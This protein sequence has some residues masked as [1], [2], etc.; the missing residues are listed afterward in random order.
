MALTRQNT[1]GLVCQARHVL[2]LS[3]LEQCPEVTQWSRTRGAVVVLGG[4]SNVILPEVLDRL[5]VRVALKGMT[6]VED[7]D[8]SSAQ[9]WRIDVAA[10][11]NWHDW[12]QT[13][14]RHGWF[15]LENLAL[16]PGTVG[17]APVQNIGA[18]GVELK[19]RIESVTAW[20]IPEGRLITLPAQDC[21]FA[22]RD[23][24]F[25]RAA[26]GTWLIVSV[27]F[28]LPKRWVPVL[29]YPDLRNHPV[30]STME[31]ERVTGQHIL[32]AVCEIRRAKLPDPEVLGNAG[33]FFKNPVVSAA[34]HQQLKEKFVD[35]IAYPQNDG[36]FKL[37]AGWMIERC[38]WKGRRLGHVGVH[39]RQALVLVNY[40]QANAA[41]LL[42]LAQKISAS[43]EAL[44]GVKLEIEPV[45]VPGVSGPR[46]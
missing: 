30:L 31:P 7:P 44:F 6:P 8:H 39:E 4:G 1:L 45:V 19:D 41:E 37:A 36:S 32:D 5:V 43:V 42:D 3:S 16:I 29:T 33:S 21:A 25:K 23:S 13:A 10:G 11:E 28:M 17:A 2:T 22:Y 35:L 24:I 27:R 9:T 34:L 20:N 40:G 26:P 12:V 18:Y 14:T 15:G 46:V 38:G